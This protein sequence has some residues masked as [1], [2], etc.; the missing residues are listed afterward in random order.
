MKSPL[1]I[2]LLFFVCAAHA[3]S[4]RQVSMTDMAQK[5]A[6]VFEGTVVSV[7]THQNDR[8]A[9]VTTIVFDVIDVL[10]GQWSDA[11]LQLDFLG[12]KFQGKTMSVSDIH[13]P[14]LG[15]KGIY[16][17]ES[18]DT[19]MIN[20]LLG[21]DQGRFIVEKDSLGEDKVLTANRKPIERIEEVSPELNTSSSAN[22]ELSNGVA[23]GVAV[24]RSFLKKNALSKDQFKK[25]IRLMVESAE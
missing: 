22:L 11:Q 19:P 2:L 14:A 15:E 7:T 1:F 18:T 9:I 13:Y 6:L 16:F 5:S 23:K 8:G 3:S 21:W 4:V 10:K 17:V 20:P 12:G 24:S 25:E